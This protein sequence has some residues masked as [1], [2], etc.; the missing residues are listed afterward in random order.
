[1]K[2]KSFQDFISGLMFL[3]VGAAFAV[4]ASG[5]SLGTS[6]RPGAGFFPLILSGLL[7]LLGLL[8]LFK[9]LTFETSAVL[10]SQA[11][12]AWRPLGVV[13]LSIVVFALALPR[14]GLLITIPLQVL[15]VSLASDDSRW[16][17][18][19]LAAVVLT[20]GSWA[21]FVWGLKLSLPLLPVGW[22]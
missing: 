18:A 17:G 10:H 19:L 20:A 15:L 5:Y 14:L 22:A 3:V 6:A 9:A 13:V 11:G 4:G 2:I 7:M 8:V 1:M 12:I 16:R 21:I